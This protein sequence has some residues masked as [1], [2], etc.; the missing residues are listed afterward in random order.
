MGSS[1]FP[2]VSA[3]PLPEAAWVGW[4]PLWLR[5][6]L[7]SLLPLPAGG[8]SCLPTLASH[9]TSKLATAEAPSAPTPWPRRV[10]GRTW[11][12]LWMGGWVGELYMASVLGPQLRVGLHSAAYRGQGA[13]DSGLW[14]GVGV[15]GVSASVTGPPELG[16]RT[17]IQR[18]EFLSGG[19]GN[20]GASA[21]TS[22][23]LNPSGS[24][25]WSLIP[26]FILHFPQS[27]SSESPMGAAV[28]GVINRELVA[29][30]RGL[31]WVQMGSETRSPLGD[32]LFFAR[33]LRPR[34]WSLGTLSALFLPTQG[35]EQVD[36]MGSRWWR[37]L[38]SG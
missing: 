11:T 35:Q 34:P 25:S 19:G 13:G 37:E 33:G 14:P 4:G 17:L 10:G 23:A 38:G 12:W 30:C 7:K 20:L 28:S 26:Y 6:G 21:S 24:T 36:R 8:C 29:R 27:P 5:L 1:L 22:L 9:R 16:A 31:G 3:G 2:R 18:R 32:P 15:G